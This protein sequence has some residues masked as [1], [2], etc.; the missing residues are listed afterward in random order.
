MNLT[1]FLLR[2]LHQNSSH[3]EPVSRENV[4]PSTLVQSPGISYLWK[5]LTYV[6]IPI[7]DSVGS[8]SRVYTVP[9]LQGYAQTAQNSS[10]VII[11]TCPTLRMSGLPVS[12]PALSDF[13]PIPHTFLPFF[14]T[15][16][17]RIKSQIVTLAFQ[18]QNSIGNTTIHTTFQ[19][20]LQVNSYMGRLD[21]VESLFQKHRIIKRWEENYLMQQY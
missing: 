3:H 13:L 5:E 15:Y 21:V 14:P 8:V 9:T 1:L 10:T 19:E 16:W 18:V 7:P 20:F 17:N 12:H 4:L 11:R 2:S 6:S